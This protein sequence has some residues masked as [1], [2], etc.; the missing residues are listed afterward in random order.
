MRSTVPGQSGRALCLLHVRHESTRSV[1]RGPRRGGDAA[2]QRGRPQPVLPGRVHGHRRSGRRLRSRGLFPLE[3]A[4]FAMA[5]LCG[6]PLPRG[7]LLGHGRLQCP[8]ERA[9]CAPRRRVAGGRGLLGGLSARVVEVESRANRSFA[10]VSGVPRR[11]TGDLSRSEGCRSGV[12]SRRGEASRAARFQPPMSCH[13]NHY[14]GI[15]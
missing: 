11:S 13:E 12:P 15:T 14:R 10:R 6:P 4:A 7:L 1:A 3:R 2:D 5:A 9:A 8:E